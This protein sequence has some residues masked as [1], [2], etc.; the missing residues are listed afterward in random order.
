MP[1]DENVPPARSEDYGHYPQFRPILLLTL[2]Y[3]FGHALISFLTS[4][5]MPMNSAE[6]VLLAQSLDLGYRFGHAP[7][8]TWI[9]A[10]ADM[11]IGLSRP[12]IIAIKYAAMAIGLTTFY[13]AARIVFRWEEDRTGQI[14]ERNDMSAAALAAWSMIFV[15]AWK[16]NEDQVQS[17]FLFAALA[18]TLYAFLRALDTTRIRH[19]IWFG[20]AAGVGTLISHKHALLPVALILAAWTI[21]SL[22]AVRN[23]DDGS[24]LR[25]RIGPR[26]VLMSAGIALI[27]VAPDLWWTWTHLPPLD[28]LMARVAPDYALETAASP[29]NALPEVQ[30]F[31]QSRGQGLTALLRVMAEFS[32]P[33]V[34]FFVLVFAPMWFGVIVPFF[35]HRRV[36]EN[37]RDIEWRRLALRSM[38]IGA[39]LV[40]PAVIGGMTDLR[41]RWMLPVLFC[42]PI[43]LFLQV[44]RSGPY[45]LSM[46]AFAL[47]SALFIIIVGAGRV[48]TWQLDIRTCSITECRA[49]LP[50]SD[51][52]DSLRKD[53][54]SHGTIVGAEHHLLG[55]LRLH[56]PDDR[57]LDAEFDY[58]AYP[59][60]NEER[61]MCV[62]VWRDTPVMPDEL[63][64]YLTGPMQFRRLS[65]E[66]Q[67][68]IRRTLIKSDE[69]ASVLYYR[70]L[71][72]R[73]T[74]Q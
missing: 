30:S 39:F 40:I 25:S 65:R 11:S 26:R 67:A 38:I 56:F 42:L 48:A 33:L 21:S 18:A 60:A 36:D 7:G 55:N 74:C 15:T 20:I 29:A 3:C 19:W 37:S 62:A 43:W 31:L 1:E 58:N 71:K 4:P 5:N 17:V 23:A 28:E 47:L 53:G 59:A 72:P 63:A 9:H 14:H 64:D 50:V 69:K 70:F 46:R 52:A 12:V 44:Q 10:L 35:P 8:I 54:F 32:L 34:A 61:G 22:H 41:P 6:Q 51:W 73:D 16:H 45:F 49:Y 68:A 66:P 57:V 2:V 27:L 13:L 24:P